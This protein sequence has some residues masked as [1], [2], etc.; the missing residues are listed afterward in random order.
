MSIGTI[1][2]TTSFAQSGVALDADGQLALL[3]LQN[4]QAQ[5]DSSRGDKAIGRQQFL[6]ASAK[7]VTALRDEAHD[8]LVGALVQGACTVT[9]ASIQFADALDEPACGKEKPW[10]EISSAVASGS[11]PALGKVLGD[12]PAATDRAD[13]KRAST[14]AQQAQWKIDDGQQA[15]DEANARRDKALDFVASESASKATT[16]SGI[17]AGFA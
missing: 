9:A 12:S 8:I 5:E 16:E 15:I 4:E 11:G 17:I 2:S 7:E 3:V 14:D 13:G 10:G 6:D 1:N